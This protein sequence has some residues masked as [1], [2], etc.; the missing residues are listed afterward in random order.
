MAEEE[1]DKPLLDPDNFNR[2]GIDLVTSFVLAFLNS[3]YNFCTSGAHT[4][5]TSFRTVENIT[6]RTSIRR[7]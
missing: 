2:E 4:T 3:F 5:R 7:C 6:E 1:L